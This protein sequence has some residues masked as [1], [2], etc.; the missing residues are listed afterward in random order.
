MPTNPR[1]VSRAPVRAGPKR[2]R[3]TAF[4]S[5]QREERISGG[6]TS[7]TPHWTAPSTDAP[8]IPWS[9][10]C[11]TPPNL[12]S[13]A[14]PSRD[15]G[16]SVTRLQRGLSASHPILPGR[17]R[18]GSLTP[19]LGTGSRSRRNRPGIPREH[20]L[21]RRLRTGDR[22]RRHDARHP[23]CL[24]GRPGSRYSWAD[25]TGAGSGNAGR[26]A[27]PFPT[28]SL[29][30]CGRQ[31]VGESPLGRSAGRDRIPL[32]RAWRA[33]RP[34]VRQRLFA[35]RAELP[36]GQGGLLT[37]TCGAR[38]SGR[39]RRQAHRMALGYQSRGRRLRSCCD[40]IDWYRA[41]EIEIFFHVLRR[42]SVEALQLGHI[43]KI[44]L[45]LA[46]YL[47]VAWRLAHLVRLGRTP[48]GLV[49]LRVVQEAEGRAH[50]SWLRKRRP[51]H[52]PTSAR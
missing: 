1:R 52:R 51:P 23:S 45:A 6:K 22:S 3:S 43:D 34:L 41:G 14:R 33:N 4:R 10:V 49:R 27:G 29:S 9:C 25:A 39:P 37:V 12:T 7:L 21:D 38:K 8:S 26:L 13:S 44:E 19:A 17:N 24:R 42:L 35:C 30:S 40:V 16:H 2:G 36:N 32:A 15:W 48:S 47:V 31:T 50:T 5:G 11:R 46:V 20:P 18:R 28:Q